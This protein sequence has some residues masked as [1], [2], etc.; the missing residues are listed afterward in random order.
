MGTMF[1]FLFQSYAIGGHKITK[2][3]VGMR[4]IGTKRIVEIK[5]NRS[6]V[7]INRHVY[8]PI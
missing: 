4:M 1:V 8:P 6:D 2:E 5:D 3:I 7:A